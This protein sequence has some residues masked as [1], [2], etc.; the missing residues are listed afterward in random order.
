MK[1]RITP[2]IVAPRSSP[3][4]EQPAQKWKLSNCTEMLSMTPGC[5]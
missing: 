1:L 5:S 2:N 3:P 4:P